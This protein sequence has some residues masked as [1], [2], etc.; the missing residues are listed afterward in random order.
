MTLFELVLLALANYRL[1]RLI[2]IDDGPFDIFFRLRYWLGAYDLDATGQ[3]SS[4]W[5]R[6]ISCPHCVGMYAALLLWILILLP[7]GHAVLW[8]LAIAGAQS[9]LWSLADR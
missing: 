6:G 9:L 5:G 1:A 8:I 7:G 3:P 2:A 4:A